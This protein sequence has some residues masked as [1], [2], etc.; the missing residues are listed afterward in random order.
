MR[1]RCVRCETA[2]TE[3]KTGYCPPLAKLRLMP[4]TTETEKE[5]TIDT[6]NKKATVLRWQSWGHFLLQWQCPQF[7]Q[8]RTV[9]CFFSLFDLSHLTHRCPSKRFDFCDCFFE[10][11][12]P[13][14]CFLS[15]IDNK[16]QHLSGSWKSCPSY[17]RWRVSDPITLGGRPSLLCL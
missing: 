16:F 13:G 7:Y 6:Q 9:V 10:S 4:S 11:P 3:K 1:L 2:N 12:I 17:R 15:S 8:R 14:L 5:T